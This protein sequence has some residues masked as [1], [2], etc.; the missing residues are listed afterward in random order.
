VY[1]CVRCRR[2]AVRSKRAFPPASADLPAESSVMS[3]MTRDSRV[4]C[5]GTRLQRDKLR[6]TISRLPSLLRHFEDAR[7][8]FQVP[9]LCAGCALHGLTTSGE[10]G[11]RSGSDDPI[12]R[13][14]IQSSN[15]R[16]QDRMTVDI[17]RQH[18]HIDASSM[19]SVC[20][21]TLE[22]QCFDSPN[23]TDSRFRAI[24]HSLLERRAN[25]GLRR[26]MASCGSRLRNHSHMSAVMPKSCR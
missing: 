15:A 18:R 23:G 16:L 5:R 11:L 2:L 10:K 6:F 13:R 25:P 26:K 17:Q 4:H 20:L 19:F 3:S 7:R 24:A 22:F 12:P 14:R 1:H 8:G 21:E 9:P